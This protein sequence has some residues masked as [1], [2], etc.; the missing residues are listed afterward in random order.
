MVRI[1]ALAAALSLA[2]PAVP[3]YAQQSMFT[4]NGTCSAGVF[5]F[6]PRI[7]RKDAVAAIG[8][9]AHVTVREYCHGQQLN[10]LG[11]AADLTRTIAN[12]PTLNA[13]I[14]RFGWTPDDVVG[15]NIRGNN[16]DLLVH[17]Y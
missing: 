5:N 11:N 6:L 17:R 1:F 10:D 13:A 2:V 16:V 8:P 4:P 12:N 7:V 3:A 15:I 9:E 14:R